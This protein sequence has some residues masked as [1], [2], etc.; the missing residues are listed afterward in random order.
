MN[1]VKTGCQV[2]QELR[3]HRD[4]EARQDYQGQWDLQ[5]RWVQPD[6]LVN[7]DRMDNEENL[8]LQVSSGGRHSFRTNVGYFT[9]SFNASFKCFIT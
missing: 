7:G 6:L 4:H 5:D 8:G 3:D 1:V 9:L 2:N